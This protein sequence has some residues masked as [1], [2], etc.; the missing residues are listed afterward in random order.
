MW[1]WSVGATKLREETEIRSRETFPNTTLA[2]NFDLALDRTRRSMVTGRQ[3]RAFA[4]ARQTVK[5]VW[6]KLSVM[7]SF[8]DVLSCKCESG[9]IE[10]DEITGVCSTHR[11]DEEGRKT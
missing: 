7:K 6:D 9:Y 4:M 2:Q 3:L 10:K 8:I 11:T 1:E 5:E